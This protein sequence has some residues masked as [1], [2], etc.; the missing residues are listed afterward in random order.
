MM[1]SHLPPSCAAALIPRRSIGAPGQNGPAHSDT[2]W[3]RRLRLSH[4]CNLS[5]GRAELTNARS[6]F[7]HTSEVDH[8]GSYPRSERADQGFAEKVTVFASGKAG[9]AFS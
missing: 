2:P 5:S 8:L 4:S 3:C 9:N 6:G 1:K 7:V